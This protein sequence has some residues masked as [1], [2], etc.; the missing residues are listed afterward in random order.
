VASSKRTNTGSRPRRARSLPLSFLRDEAKGLE[1][2]LRQTGTAEPEEYERYRPG[3][4]D[5]PETGAK[6]WYLYCRRLSRLHAREEF[7]EGRPTAANADA[8]ELL[9]A[10][11]IQEPIRIE[12]GLVD[13][14]TIALYPK[15]WY[16]LWHLARRDARLKELAVLVERI[17]GPGLLEYQDLTDR[18]LEEMAHQTAVIVW[19]LSTPGHGLPFDPRELPR[20]T[21][22]A[23]PLDLDSLV[24]ARY[25]RA[26]HEVHG[27]RL[28]GLSAMIDVDAKGDIASWNTFFST[29][30]MRLNGNTTDLVEDRDLIG[31]LMQVAQ[32]AD[33]E[34]KAIERAKQDAKDE[35]A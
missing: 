12:T 7:S 22:P 11:M 5:N 4:P 14:S 26:H 34:K 24:I 33:A 1:D 15:S 35:A 25:L 29:V 31:L 13:P 28:L 9:T 6:G 3:N 18:A 21:P 20:P 2:S 32:A 27:R 23:W 16:A 19:S 17:G 8:E 30:A 10:G